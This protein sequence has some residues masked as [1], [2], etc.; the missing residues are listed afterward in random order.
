MRETF[1]LKSYEFRN[2]PSILGYSRMASRSTISRS[3][4]ERDFAFSAAFMQSVDDAAAMLDTDGI[5]SSVNAALTDLMQV[6]ANDL[7]GRSLA[8]VFESE[9]PKIEAAI[10]NEMGTD[11]EFEILSGKPSRL[12]LVPAP[13]K[14]GDVSGW[15]AIFRSL[16]MPNDDGIV[17]ADSFDPL[18]NL[19]GRHLVVSRLERLLN[20]VDNEQGQ[21]TI[22]CVDLDG[23]GRVNTE[24]GR[25][26]GDNILVETSR[27][28]GRSMRASNII[29]RL[30]EDMFIVVVPDMR[31]HEQI[32]AVASRLISNIAVPF[33]VKGVRD[34][35]FL[36]TS[37][38]IA[39]APENGND[40]ESLI[41]YAQSA[42]ERAKQSGPGT[43]QF[44][45][46]DTGGEVRERRSQVN[47]LRRAID[48]DQM[49]LLYQ[50]KVSLASGEIVAAEALVRWQDPESGMIL[51][52]DFIPLAE[53]AG[54]ID[55][56]GHKILLQACETLRGWQDADMPF[57]RIAV[58]VSAREIARA[59]FFEDLT[60][61][62]KETGIEPD[63][64]ELE[65][66]ESAVME[67]AEEVI[68]S[69]RQIRRLGV[70]LTADDFGTGYAS[71][72]YLRN[73][74]LDGIKIDTTFVGDID[75]DQD[76]D[77]G[78]L[79]S[80]VIAVGHCL[81]M[82]VVAEGVET[83]AQLNYLRWRD[84]D[85][86]QGYLISEPLSPDD[87]IAM[88]KKGPAI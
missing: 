9:A 13:D 58:N 20:A 59:S 49:R 73:F 22:L 53:D 51:P 11:F 14:N 78:G 1:C 33:K 32:N 7:I 81:G 21:V 6:Q 57:L 76:G 67:S 68:Q 43:Y 17:P 18:T 5:V 50:P 39:I 86:V 36:T 85:E 19:P 45:T 71:L 65:I 62:L 66:T 3:S 35:V 56:L 25:A 60:H 84:C 87:F 83:Q 23:F 79:A 70:H 38:G 28:L 31:S 64:L 12:Q 10:S 40:A 26:V 80:A 47:R 4:I 46:N 44:Y 42:V 75:K 52:A 82:N 77:G 61:I 8:S 69:L 2:V 88:V 55:P 16:K 15:I 74:P 41:N 63:A 48:D 27:R 72:S 30:Q 29:G 34:S 54:L 24:F 37:V